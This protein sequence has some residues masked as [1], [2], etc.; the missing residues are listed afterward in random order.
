M[1]K[2]LFE[3]FLRVTG[4]WRMPNPHHGSGAAAVT[5]L[6]SNAKTTADRPPLVV[7]AGA[8]S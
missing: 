4:L 3:Y 7:M 1:K 2:L 5:R 6:G 8:H